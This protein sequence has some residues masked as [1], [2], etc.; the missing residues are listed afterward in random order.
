ML[1]YNIGNEV[2]NTA[3]NTNSAREFEYPPVYEIRGRVTGVSWLI[4]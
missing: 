4:V 3:A 1:G 2:V